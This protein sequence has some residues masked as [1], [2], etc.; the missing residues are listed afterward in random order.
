MRM[1]SRVHAADRPGPGGHNH[2]RAAA[3]GTA[4]L[5]LVMLPA[6]TSAQRSPS[7]GASE[8][9]QAARQ[10]RDRALESNI[11]Y[12]IVDS[13][14]TMG[15]RLAGTPAEHRAAA[16][17]ADYMRRLGFENV[18]I[19]EFPLLVW[20][21]GREEA[22]IVS[23]HEQP[24]VVTMLGGSPATPPAGI[25]AE[26]VLFETLDALLDAPR[27]S[28]DGR[29][30]VLLQETPRTQAGSGYGS[31][32]PMR[33]RGP[34]EAA[35]RGAV[36]FVLRSLGTHDHRFAHTGATQIVEN[37]VP[38]FAMSPPDAE[39]LVRLTRRGPVRLRLLGMPQPPVQGRSQNVIGEVRGRER[40]DEVIVIGGHVD[41]W[42]L[43][44]GALDDA[45]GVGITTAAAHLIAALPQRPRRTIRVVWWG[46]EE[47][48]Q[49]GGGLPGA[50]HYA[51]T[52]GDEIARHVIA[53]ES[54]FGAG[55]IY[56]LNLPAGM[57][58][59]E[60]R[61]EAMA[62]L[63]PLGIHFD[64]EPARGG[65]PDVIPLVQLG[66]P[67]FS[68]NQDGTDYFD[69]HHTVDDV[70]ERIDRRHLDQN[71]AAWAAL[72]WLIAESDIDFRAAAAQ[73][74]DRTTP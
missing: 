4:V 62:V 55:P 17:G 34:A 6:T 43:G 38:S 52:R 10:L 23:P 22:R 15:P 35:A 11:A 59:S 28:L 71:V 30:A 64:T 57:A 65:G 7:P 29:I 1:M 2:P 3:V 70:I 49:P 60:L 61:R 47:V 56:S 37:T 58:E 46:A 18:R 68:L 40:P 69:V 66:V 24:L 63:A 21:R 44:T 31:T 14:T 13:L 26:V 32:S 12:A 39:Q 8:R 67:A 45:A 27:G 16:W 53:S 25:E 51:N 33:F 20:T 19:E 74:A 73:A 42:D 36:G 41:S 48:S 72:V 9:V 50:R 5:L 54:D